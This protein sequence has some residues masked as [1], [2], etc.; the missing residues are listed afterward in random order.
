MRAANESTSVITN[1]CV[2]DYIY[3]YAYLSD[4]DVPMVGSNIEYIGLSAYQN[5]A[6]IL[7][8]FTAV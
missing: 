5:L 3:I 6:D 8:T 2:P 7:N 4:S 1:S